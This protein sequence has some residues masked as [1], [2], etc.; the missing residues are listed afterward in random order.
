MNHENEVNAAVEELIREEQNAERRIGKDFPGYSCFF[1]G[2]HDESLGPCKC[3][4][5]E[6]F[7]CSQLKSV[8]PK[9]SDA[10]RKVAAHLNQLF[11]EKRLAVHRADSRRCRLFR[12]L[13]NALEVLAQDSDLAAKTLR[14]QIGA[15]AD[16]R[17]DEPNDFQRAV[18]EAFRKARFFD[19][20]R[21]TVELDEQEKLYYVERTAM[22][23]LF[24]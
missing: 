20:A 3:A 21:L 18:L 5:P 2:H 16:P 8:C 17:A 6:A 19:F 14:F 9:C 13:R 7:K 22:S 12:F 23:G 15:H 1:C 24:R 11:K 10:H 4:F